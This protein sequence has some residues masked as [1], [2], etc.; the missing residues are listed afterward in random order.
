MASRLR[1]GGGGVGLEERSLVF[2]LSVS[3][4]F[5]RMV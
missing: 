5:S 4:D 1:H 2:V 3:D